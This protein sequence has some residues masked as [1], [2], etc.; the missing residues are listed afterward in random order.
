MYESVGVVSRRILPAHGHDE[1]SVLIDLAGSGVR[2]RAGGGDPEHRVSQ[3]Q[4]EVY[5]VGIFKYRASTY[6]IGRW[7]EL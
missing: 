6:T 2:C 3:V 5:Q 1:S 4:R 7:Y